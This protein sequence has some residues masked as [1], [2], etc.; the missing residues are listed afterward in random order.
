MYT[1]NSHD[2]FTEY[3]IIAGHSPSSNIALQG[4]FDMPSRTGVLSHDWG[5]ENGIEPFVSADDIFFEGRSVNFSGSIKGSN[6]VLNTKLKLL[7][8]DIKS[9]SGLSI[10]STPYGDFSVL[11]NQINPEYVNGG[12]SVYM[13]FREPV[14]DLSGGTIPASGTSA[15]TIDSIPFL[16]FGLYLFNSKDIYSLPEFKEMKYTSYGFE[17]Y[18]ITKRKN[19]ILTLNGFVIGSSLIDFK[20]KI[21]ALYS[22][23]S[24]VGLRTIKLNGE[25]S[26]SC[27]ATSGFKTENIYLYN[28]G[29]VCNFRMSLMVISVTNL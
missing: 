10:F 12:C 9:F 28:T 26:V 6:S 20:N 3:G 7:Y 23:F 16:S 24:S 14:V 11:V 22:L 21:K 18:Q 13:Q 2:L 4:C 25:V 19:N 29:I 27:F 1:L 17:G 5:D 8:D 15:N